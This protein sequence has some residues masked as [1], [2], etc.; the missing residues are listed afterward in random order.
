L[1]G[2]I[3]YA[4]LIGT[5]FNLVSNKHKVYLSLGFL[6]L[7]GGYDYALS[8]KVSIGVNFSEISGVFASAT[9]A[10]VNVNYHFRSAF[11]KSWVLG[12]DVGRRDL[13][14]AFTAAELDSSNVAFVSVGY[15]F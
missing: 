4:G 9:I 5:Q 15:R 13:N 10:S 7:G 6:G 1:G 3:Q 8:P 11:D 2:G 12:L 14:T